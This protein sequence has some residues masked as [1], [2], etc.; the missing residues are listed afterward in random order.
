[1]ESDREAD[2]L[3][4]LLA[5]EHVVEARPAL[6]ASIPGTALTSRTE[7]SKESFNAGPPETHLPIQFSRFHIAEAVGFRAGQQ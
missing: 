7:P 2:W 6:R 4:T 1:M 5:R 3:G